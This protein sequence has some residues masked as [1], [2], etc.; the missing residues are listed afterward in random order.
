MKKLA[1]ENVNWEEPAR[2]VLIVSAFSHP[3]ENDGGLI[4]VSTKNANNRINNRFG[5]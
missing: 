4:H 2:L 1:A 3:I 5:A